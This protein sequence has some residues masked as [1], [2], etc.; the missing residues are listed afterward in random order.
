MG[1]PTKLLGV[2]TNRTSFLCGKRHDYH[3]TEIVRK[4]YDKA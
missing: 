4:T 1:P 3:N 2:R